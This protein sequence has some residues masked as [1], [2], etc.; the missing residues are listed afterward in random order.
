[1]TMS[2][3]DILE[4][5]A[6]EHNTLDSDCFS[7]RLYLS[8]TPANGGGGSAFLLLSFLFFC[9]LKCCYKSNLLPK[10]RPPSLVFN[11]PSQIVS[12]LSPILSL[13]D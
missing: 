6:Q 7:L 1:M 4:F 13:L 8:T 2:C 5:S 10:L 9:L 11:F 3:E 12:S